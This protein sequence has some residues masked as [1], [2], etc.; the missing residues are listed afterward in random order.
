MII[1]QPDVVL[2]PFLVLLLML[3]SGAGGYLQSYLYGYAGVQWKADHLQF[4]PILP[5]AG[6]SRVTLRAMNYAEIAFTFSYTEDTMCF[7]LV[8]GYYQRSLSVQV[9]G[10]GQ[11]TMGYEEKCISRAPGRVLQG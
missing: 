2:P 10:S 11:F 6:V 4:N 3:P 7:V 8:T 9:E 5:P 1:H